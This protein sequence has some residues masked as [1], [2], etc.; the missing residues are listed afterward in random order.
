MHD[1]DVPQPRTSTAH[2]FQTLRV[3]TLNVDILKSRSGGSVEMLEWRRV[4]LCCIQE[5]R[6]KG[7]STRFLIEK[8]IGIRFSGQETLMGHGYTS[9]KK[10]DWYSNWGIQHYSAILQ[11]QNTDC[12]MW[13]WI[14]NE[15]G[16]KKARMVT[17]SIPFN[18]SLLYQD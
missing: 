1:V 6:W 2:T 16:K 9:C 14:Y 17:T 8:S 18:I 12:I 5:V 10:T 3:G 7:S 13:S 4:D 11:K 15:S